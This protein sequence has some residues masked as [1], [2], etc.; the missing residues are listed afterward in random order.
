M[1]A[2]HEHMHQRAGQQEQVGQSTQQ[3]GGVLR[4]QKEA[5]D[6]KG[7]QQRQSRR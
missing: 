6:R 3:V 4:D 5:A 7:Y 1:A 2:V